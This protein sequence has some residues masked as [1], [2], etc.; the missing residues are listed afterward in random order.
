MHEETKI[1]CH[2]HEYTDVRG[3]RGSVYLYD[4]PAETGSIVVKPNIYRIYYAAM[5]GQNLLF[6]GTKETMTAMKIPSSIHLTF[7]AMKFP[8]FAIPDHYIGGLGIGSD[9]RYGTSTTSL[10]SGDSI[11]FTSAHF[12]SSHLF[13]V[14][15]DSSFRQISRREGSIDCFDIKG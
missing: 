3:I 11:Y 13:Q 15:S 7:P 14:T 10:C 9:C 5:T 6:A 1:V 4:I 12:E 2:G 8:G